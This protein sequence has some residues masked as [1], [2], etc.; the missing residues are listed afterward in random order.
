MIMGFHR[1]REGVQL[2]ATARQE[3]W[4][5]HPTVLERVAR[6]FRSFRG[7]FEAGWKLVKIYE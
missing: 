4:E 5:K 2:D 6:D 1:V 7:D 3:L